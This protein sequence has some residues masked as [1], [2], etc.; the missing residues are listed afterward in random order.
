MRHHPERIGLWRSD[1]ERMIT[2]NV[3]L[4]PIRGVFFQDLGWRG[5]F[6]FRVERDHFYVGCALVCGVWWRDDAG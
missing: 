1:V 2:C 5:G 4:G 3:N 6:F